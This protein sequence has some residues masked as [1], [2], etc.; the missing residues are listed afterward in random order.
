MLTR[1]AILAG[2]AVTGMGFFVRGQERPG[3][4]WRAAVIGHT[5]KGDFGH[6]LDT[7]FAGRGDVEVVAVADANDAGRARAVERCRAN[8]GDADYREMLEKE[9]PSLVS[10]APRTTGERREMLLAALAAG[11]HVVSE[12]PF[13]RTPADGYEVLKLAADKHLRTAVA[14]QMHVAPA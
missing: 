13:V 4:K 5:G 1:R 9:K 12:K 14:H 2:A 11:A 6:G 7:I 3:E 8:K 10:V